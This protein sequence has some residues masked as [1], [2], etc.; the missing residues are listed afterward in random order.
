MAKAYFNSEN[1]SSRRI[2]DSGRKLFTQ[3][4]APNSHVSDVFAD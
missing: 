4:L 3:R 2:R 1:F